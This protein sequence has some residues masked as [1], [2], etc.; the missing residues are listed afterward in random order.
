MVIIFSYLCALPVN[1]FY[2]FIGMY[3]GNSYIKFWKIAPIFQ[4]TVKR[5]VSKRSLK[6]NRISGVGFAIMALPFCDTLSNL[7]VSNMSIGYIGV[8]LQANIPWLNCRFLDKPATKCFTMYPLMRFTDMCCPNATANCLQKYPFPALA[9][10]QTVGKYVGIGPRLVNYIILLTFTILN[11]RK[12]MTFVTTLTLAFGFV[13]L[14]ILGC[15]VYF[16]Q[17]YLMPD[18]FH[19][20]PDDF[21]K[22]F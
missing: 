4:G 10:F 16:G 17:T 2:V 6:K 7:V 5:N 8:S 11:I 14:P 12:Y 3:T 20:A 22:V 15:T 9:Y 1:F 19:V 13:L 18:A 21:R